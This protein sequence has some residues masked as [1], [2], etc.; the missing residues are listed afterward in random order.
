MGSPEELKHH[1]KTLI[2]VYIPSPEQKVL[3]MPHKIPIDA[4]PAYKK[5]LNIVNNI[6]PQY[7]SVDTRCKLNS[8]AAHQLRKHNDKR[9]LKKAVE[10]F[11]EIYDLQCGLRGSMSPRAIAA[12]TWVSKTQ[13]IYEKVNIR[14]KNAVKAEREAQLLHEQKKKMNE[15]KEIEKNMKRMK[16]NINID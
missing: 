9:S 16:K 11:M 3:T 4:S 1:K 2:V 7:D 14:N 15:K 10:L 12:Y 8:K 6:R 5:S 13:D